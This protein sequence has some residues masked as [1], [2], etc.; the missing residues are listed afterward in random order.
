MNYYAGII[1]LAFTRGVVSVTGYLLLVHIIFKGGTFFTFM[2]AI[3]FA[4][5]TFSLNV[6]TNT[7]STCIVDT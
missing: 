1:W 3:V 5:G 6:K 4:V 7:C 2:N